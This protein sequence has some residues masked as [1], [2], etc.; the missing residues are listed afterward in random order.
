MSH[1]KLLSVLAI[2]LGLAAPQAAQAEVFVWK[3]HD[4]NVSVIYPDRWSIIN[5]QAYDEILR[6]AAPVV[7]DRVEEA[8]C[9]VRVRDDQRFKM[10]LISH[11]DEIQRQYFGLEF[12][13][14]YINE[15]K[16]SHVNVVQNNVGLGRGAAS[17]VD[18]IFESY[19][20]PLMTRRGIAFASLYE[21]QVHI[22]ECS[23]QHESFDKWYPTFMKIAQSVGFDR[24]STL[25]KHGY[26][27]NF[28]GGKTTI[29]GRRPID[30]Y[31]F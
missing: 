13:D 15:F 5:N 28:Y 23:V 19:E 9:R 24:V 31:E 12:W 7:S 6:I 14:K 11:S 10:H 2:A 4:Y 21:N 29:K 22:L 1:K 18:M 25:T 8:Q 17:Y 20:Y 27:R 16:T 3:N 30:D 26:Y